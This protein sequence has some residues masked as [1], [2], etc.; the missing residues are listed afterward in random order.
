M[1]LA[2]EAIFCPMGIVISGQN[3]LTRVFRKKHA[4][5]DVEWYFYRAGKKVF[6][7]KTSRTSTN[8]VSV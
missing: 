7:R 8:F 3:P 5:L 6:T 1:G 4:R 2:I